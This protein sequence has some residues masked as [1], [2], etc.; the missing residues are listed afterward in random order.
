MFRKTPLI[1]PDLSFS[2]L[3]ICSYFLAQSE[4]QCSYK[5]CSYKKTECTSEKITDQLDDLIKG[6]SEELIAHLKKILR[7]SIL[8]LSK[9][10]P[11]TKIDNC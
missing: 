4:L 5:V 3:L 2:L 11:S 7:L 8:R 9:D 6:K 1:D 10:S